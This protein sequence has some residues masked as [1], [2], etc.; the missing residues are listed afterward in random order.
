MTEILF[1]AKRIDN[2]EFVQGY[3]VKHGV[4]WWIYTGSEEFEVDEETIE[5]LSTEVAS[6]NGD[7]WIPVGDRLPEEHEERTEILNVDFSVSVCHKI[8]D[9]VLVTVHN[10][11]QDIKFVAKDCTVDGKWSHERENG[12]FKVLAW[13]P[14]PPAYEPKE[15]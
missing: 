12:C 1:R 4:R 9:I 15:D 7:G 8:S 10:I 14:L 13:Q 6:Q 11:S 2:G 3:A 5:V